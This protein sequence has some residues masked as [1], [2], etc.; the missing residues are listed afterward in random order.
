[1]PA[2]NVVV[3]PADAD[4]ADPHTN[5]AGAV[6]GART[7]GTFET[8]GFDAD[9][10]FHRAHR[11]PFGYVGCAAARQGVHAFPL[12]MFF[13]YK[14]QFQSIPFRVSPRKTEATLTDVRA[15]RLE[16]TSR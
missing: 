9:Q 10:G 16:A 11:F 1:M 15:I 7:L 14:E 13:I 6:L 4:M 5:M 8:A 3:G 2:V 12:G